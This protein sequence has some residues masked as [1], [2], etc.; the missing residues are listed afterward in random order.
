MGCDYNIETA[1]APLK[2]T[3]PMDVLHCNTVP[4]ALK[5]LTVSAI[6][7]NLVRLVM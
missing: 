1:V 7:Y 5:E 4:G 6:V 2:T 3:L